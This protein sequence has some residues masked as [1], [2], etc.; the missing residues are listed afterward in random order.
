MVASEHVVVGIDVG[1]SKANLRAGRP[2]R[3]PAVDVEVESYGWHRSGQEGV[4]DGIARLLADVVPGEVATVVVGAHGCDTREECDRLADLLRRGAS[5]TIVVLND[6]ELVFATA[7]ASP[8]I[9]LIAGTGAIGV[10]YDAHGVLLTAGGWGGVLGDEGSATGLV[11]DAAKKVVRAHDRGQSLDPLG[12]A[13]FDAFGATEMR[14]LTAAMGRLPS[15][16]AWAPYMPAV[17]E[18]AI[19]RGS[20]L[21]TEVLVESATALVEL[22]RILASRGADRQRILAAGGVI[23][24]AS[25]MRETL[26]AALT[27]EFPDSS[28]HLLL[29]P[30]VAGA[31][32][33]AEEV[34]DNGSG[35]R[36]RRS[37]NGADQ[38]RPLPLAVERSTAP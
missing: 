33:L 25:W 2:G 1:G 18:Q 8:G 14:E 5:G 27:R 20:R 35:S 16:T 26:R 28:I 7:G 17:F 23:A 38:G 4:A 37:S 13:L 11:R 12:E 30:P 21:A 31:Y 10:G 29:E 3:L 9:A 22:V 6:A 34:F 19:A 32:R 24:H 15:P 36:C